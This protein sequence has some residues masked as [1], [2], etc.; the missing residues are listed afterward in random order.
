MKDHLDMHIIALYNIIELY[1]HNLRHF[2]VKAQL[3]AN[4]KNYPLQWGC[5]CLCLG[6]LY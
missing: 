2:T 6:K 5:A 1:K 3:R 4:K